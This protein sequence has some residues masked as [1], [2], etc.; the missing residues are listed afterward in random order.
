MPLTDMEDDVETIEAEDIETE[1]VNDADNEI[2]ESEQPEAED[3]KEEEEKE[4]Y[5]RRVKKRIDQLTARSKAAEEALELERQQ[6]ADLAERLENLEKNQ[7]ESEA[8]TVETEWETKLR[9]A[10]ERKKNAFDDGDFEA[11]D[12]AD[13]EIYE[14]RQRIAQEKQRRETPQDTP[15]PQPQQPQI[16]EAEARWMKRNEWFNDERNDADRRLAGM[17]YQRMKDQERKD[18]YSDE[19]YDELDRRLQ[20]AAPHLKPKQPPGKPSASPVAGG[21]RV[22]S[23]AAKSTT[24]FT[25][26]DQAAMVKYNFGDPDNAEDRK[27]WLRHSRGESV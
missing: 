5:S 1:E 26:A 11:L 7:R 17:L 19:F 9:Q 4:D 20:A 8:R 15:Q 3:E 21:S 22:A 25:A 6:R 10:K 14:I 24:K 13:E 16:V 2:I 27:A 12:T 23:A 18:H